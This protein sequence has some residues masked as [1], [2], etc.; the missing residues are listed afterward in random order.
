MV[1]TPEVL[2]R[3]GTHPWPNTLA[4]QLQNPETMLRGADIRSLYVV[5]GAVLAQP[6]VASLCPPLAPS[7]CS[8]HQ[9][10]ESGCMKAMVYKCAGLSDSFIRCRGFQLHE[11]RSFTP[12]SL[13]LPFD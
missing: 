8:D 11:A 7:Q 6:S 12:V 4:E 9:T 5:E 3:E 2:P 10:S 1:L 13:A